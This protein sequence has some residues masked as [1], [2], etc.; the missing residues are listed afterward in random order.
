MDP[1]VSSSNESDVPPVV[2]VMQETSTVNQVLEKFKRIEHNFN[3]NFLIALYQIKSIVEGETDPKDMQ[4]SALLEAAYAKWYNKLQSDPRDMSACLLL[5]ESVKDY[6][7]LLMKRDTQ[8]FTINGDFFSNIFDEKGI[9]TPYL[10]DSLADGL[11]VEESEEKT[12]IPAEEKDAK[13]NLWNSIIGLYRLCVLICIYLQMPLVKEIIDMILVNNP[14]LNQKNI[15][16]KIFSEFKGKRRLRKMIM[17]LLKNNGDS[18]GDIFNSLQKVI[19][20]FSS[21]VNTTPNLDGVKQKVRGMFDTILKEAEITGLSEAQTDQLIEA[22]EDKKTNV[23]ESMIEEKLVTKEQ[24]FQVDQLYRKNGL[25]KMNVS[26][27][28]KDLGSTMNEM[29]K[30]IESNDE[31]AVKDILAKAGSGM[32]LGGSE[33]ENMHEELSRFEKEAEEDGDSD[34][35]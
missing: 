27:V 29:M 35:E 23:L 24:L 5:Y 18:F 17:K 1:V 21:E 12:D 16:E 3:K 7:E 4:Q 34:D 9:D 31:S 6:H 25:D 30:A 2:P 32:N 8:L 19:S 14:D 13:E 20:T 10:F 22:L 28:V 11:D 33:L 15:F 26:K